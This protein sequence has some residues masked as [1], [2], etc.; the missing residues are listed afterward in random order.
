M[1]SKDLYELQDL[2]RARLGATGADEELIEKYLENQRISPTQQTVLTAAIAELAAVEG[3]AGILS[4]ALNARTDAE[5]RFFVRSVTML[6]WY[7]LN[8]SPIVSVITDA[9]IPAGTTDDGK[10]VILFATDHIYWTEGVAQTAGIYNTALSSYASTDARE[11]W[12]LGT[13]S[14]R[15]SHEL[16]ALG[17][18]VHY[19]L[20]QMLADESA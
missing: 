6:A 17:W 14:E 19:E 11:L 18:D 9:A 13:T 7:H 1:W 15:C 16:T 8:Q 2:N 12:I 10:L 20:A 5:V 4:E 3:R